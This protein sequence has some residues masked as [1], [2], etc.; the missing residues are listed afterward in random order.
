M[1]DAQWLARGGLARPDPATFWRRTTEHPNTLPTASR[2]GTA[3][4]SSRLPT[5]LPPA[6]RQRPSARARQATPQLSSNT[7]PTFD[8]CGH[9]LR[10]DRV[11]FDGDNMAR[12]NSLRHKK[13]RGEVPLG[14]VDEARQ[15][16]AFRRNARQFGQFCPP[17]AEQCSL[18]RISRVSHA[19]VP[20][21][22]SEGVLA[23]AHYGMHHC[24]RAP[25]SASAASKK[26]DRLVAAANASTY[27]P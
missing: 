5:R 13:N 6:P 3:P 15:N 25:F 1:C 8:I 17:S 16:S 22:C 12:L 19:Q 10:R 20:I 24:C 2:P 18:P 26:H 7:L 21:P 23:T 27:A 11:A 4:R 14:W 9:Q